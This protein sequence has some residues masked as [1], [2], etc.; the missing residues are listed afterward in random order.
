V[1][2]I[3]DLEQRQ[4]L[5]DL[6]DEALPE[7]YGYLQR[8][9]RNT[10]I[11]EDLTTEVFLGAVESINRSVVV[12]VTMAWLIGIAR[13]RLVDYWRRVESDERKL[14]AVTDLD[15]SLLDPW[16]SELDVLLARDVLG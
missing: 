5:L 6:Y 4:R 7:V 1:S 2:A 13:F 10:T 14:A 16:E 11:A 15:D 3:P 12:D 8:R 9:C